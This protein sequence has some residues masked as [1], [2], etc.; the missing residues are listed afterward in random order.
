MK[1]IAFTG[2]FAALLATGCSDDKKT[3]IPTNLS[4]PTPQ[5]SMAG[6]GGGAAKGGNTSGAGKAKSPGGEGKAD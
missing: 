4:Q 5:V 1:K 6:G 3:Q 2:L